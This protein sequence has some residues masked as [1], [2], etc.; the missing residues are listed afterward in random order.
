MSTTLEIQLENKKSGGPIGL[1]LTGDIADCYLIQWDKNFIRKM[2]TL[3]IDLKLYKRF[4]DDIFIIAEVMEKGSK[5]EGE[6][7]VLD[8]AKKETDYSRK[9]EDITMEIVVDVA[10]SVD[11]MRF[12]EL[13]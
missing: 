11:G 9:D 1:A 12:N 6:S 8:M 3:G 7:I 4:K 10:E 2:K 5:F 13:S